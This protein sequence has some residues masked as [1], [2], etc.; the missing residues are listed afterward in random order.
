MAMAA[1]GVSYRAITNVIPMDKVDTVDL[2]KDRAVA[3]VSPID[4]FFENTRKINLLYTLKPWTPETW[5]PEFGTLILLGYM[6]AV[7]SYFRALIAGLVN[8]DEATR[9]R[10]GPKTLT[11]GVATGHPDPSLLPEVLLEHTSFTAAKHVKTSLLE[12]L[13]LK[14][15]DFPND[16]SYALEEF[17]KICEVR[18]CCVHRF[19]KL[20]TKNAWELGFERHLSVIER[21]FSPTI[22]EVRAITA[23][24][25]TFV[26]TINNYIFH[27]M[28]DRIAFDG[29]QGKISWSWAWT[30]EADEK[31]F[32]SYYDFFAS[33]TAKPK[34]GSIE[35]VYA[36]FSA[37]HIAIL[38]SKEA[39]AR[40]KKEPGPKPPHPQDAQAQKSPAEP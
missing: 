29:P 6:S 25:M 5:E 24:L 7:E 3:K 30:F 14:H 39:K 38:K 10:A 32:R 8:L 1:T 37:H 12:F 33:V 35:D 17:D 28:L 9:R 19:G 2:F 15:Q 23:S 18:H 40:K 34:S 31:R 4:A 11:F 36:D 22:D 20:G 27:A 16:V 13:E 21:P 26:R